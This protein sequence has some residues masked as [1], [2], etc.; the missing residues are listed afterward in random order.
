MAKK[1]ILSLLLIISVIA[2]S[3]FSLTACTKSTYNLYSYGTYELGDKFYGMRLTSDMVEIT[4]D[5]GDVTLK[6]D[7][8]FLNG[9]ES[10]RGV[11]KTY[12]GSYSEDETTIIACIPEYAWSY[13]TV[14]KAGDF[15]IF[16]V[17]GSTMVVKR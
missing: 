17:S 6:I 4:L 13:I 5:N 10:K 2:I 7:E 15:L 1:R 11:Y 16:T 3:M 8:G 14:K 9:S 12:T